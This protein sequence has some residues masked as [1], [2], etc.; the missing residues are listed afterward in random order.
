MNKPHAE[1]KVRVSK[2][3]WEKW[4]RHNPQFVQ[5]GK[6]VEPSQTPSA[7]ILEA[8]LAT[9]LT[10]DLLRL[11]KEPLLDTSTSLMLAVGHVVVEEVEPGDPR[12]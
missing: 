7:A 10:N 4:L 6:Q 1:F 11:T 9:I 5:V 2:K 3:L 12:T 8:M